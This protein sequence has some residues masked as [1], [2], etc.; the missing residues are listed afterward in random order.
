[1]LVQVGVQ[2][3]RPLIPT[4]TKINAVAIGTPNLAG[5]LILEA[6]PADFF[7]IENFFFETL[8]AVDAAVADKP[9]HEW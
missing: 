9:R 6:S 8:A 3:F 5:W 7:L 1:M 2:K 4:F